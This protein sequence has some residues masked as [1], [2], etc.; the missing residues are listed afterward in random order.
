MNR[1]LADD[2][3]VPD[4][5]HGPIAVD[6]WL[7]HLCRYVPV[8]RAG[9]DAEGVHQLR[10]AIA[11]IRVWLE[12]GGWRILHDDLR[13][14]RRVAGAVR[15]V[16]VRLGYAAPAGYVGALAAA[17]DRAQ[18]A[19]ASAL[20]EARVATVV[21]ALHNLPTVERRHARRVLGTFAREALRRGRSLRW[22]DYPTLH[23]FRRLVRRVRFTLEWLGR[24]APRLTEAQR[25]LGDACDAWVDLR[26]VAGLPP[27]PRDYRREQ[28]RRLAATTQLARRSWHDCRIDVAALT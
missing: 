16:D 28:K 5:P 7:G 20:E 25:R 11:R 22:D 27:V 12:L 24:S 23:G 8:A 19:L 15:D 18:E 14:L 3:K 9:R 17:R 13:G 2:A 4:N 21:T 26:S 6:P 10:I 1:H